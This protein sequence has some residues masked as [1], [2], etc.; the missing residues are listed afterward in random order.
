MFADDLTELSYTIEDMQKMINN[1]AIWAQLWG[2]EFNPVK[3]KL[4]KFHS[5]NCKRKDLLPENNKEFISMP[6]YSNDS[7]FV[8]RKD[9]IV[10]I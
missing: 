6:V 4:L 10:K 2:L 9:N 8:I 1:T 5:S 7:D 3:C